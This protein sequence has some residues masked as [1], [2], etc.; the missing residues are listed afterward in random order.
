MRV[1]NASRIAFE[2][3]RQVKVLRTTPCRV[4]RRC[5]GR[6]QVSHADRVSHGA[7]RGAGWLG[8]RQD[9]RW[10]SAVTFHPIE[11]EH[12]QPV[13]RVLKWQ[14]VP[15]E[16]GTHARKRRV[17]KASASMRVVR[18]TLSRRRAMHLDDALVSMFPWAHGH[19]HKDIRDFVHA[20]RVCSPN[21]TLPYSW[22]TSWV[23]SCRRASSVS[24]ER[25]ACTSTICWFSSLVRCS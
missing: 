7:L 24:V 13:M 6:V 9:G 4:R 5:S 3:L 1:P 21:S 22:A 25:E 23:A 16:V 14:E 18:D 10:G 8:Q 15:P 20:L 17:A 19:Q 11:R 2:A 12:P